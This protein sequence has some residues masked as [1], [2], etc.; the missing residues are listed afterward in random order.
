MPI[1]IIIVYLAVIALLVYGAVK[2]YSS[3]KPEY[4]KAVL[5]SL[6]F[7]TVVLVAIWVFNIE[8]P[9]Y[10]ILLSM[11]TVFISC[12]IGHYL[13][14][15]NKSKVF[16]RYLHAF[17]TF[18]FALFT[19]S[20]LD[21]FLLAGGSRLYQALFIVF[22]GNTLGVMFEL[23]EMSHDIKP[24]VPRAQKGLIDTDMD[25]LFNLI[26]SILAGAVAYIWIIE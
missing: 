6:I 1:W 12:F 17:G 18:S 7:Y 25:Q 23:F 20:I 26:G 10:Q 16:D 4:G 3:N 19:F 11:L 15:Y 8:V 2:L 9:P 14:L 21:D 5:A 24:N 22:L 13:Q